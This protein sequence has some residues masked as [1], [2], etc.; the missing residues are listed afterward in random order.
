MYRGSAWT[1]RGNPV[2]GL[3]QGTPKPDVA[4]G[5]VP[6]DLVPMSMQEDSHVSSHLRRKTQRGSAR[7]IRNNSVTGLVEGTPEPDVVEEDVSND[8]VQ[9]PMPR[10]PRNNDKIV[11]EDTEATY[12]EE[13]IVKAVLDSDDIDGQF[14]IAQIIPSSNSSLQEMQVNCSQASEESPNSV[15]DMLWK[16]TTDM[17][18]GFDFAQSYQAV[19]V[20][21]SP[22]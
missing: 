1:I 13:V 8:L 20:R 12:N 7:T 17:S 18:V 15:D 6:N 10:S 14:I 21:L 4:E 2:A 9:I 11:Q 16:P 22:E 3:I 19:A 5:D